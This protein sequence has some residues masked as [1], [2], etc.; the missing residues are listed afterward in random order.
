MT[1]ATAGDNV[2]ML[3][4]R[5]TRSVD[6]SSG[7]STGRTL[8]PTDI[9]QALEQLVEQA[10]GTRPRPA[11]TERRDPAATVAHQRDPALPRRCVRT[12]CAN[13][14]TPT[15][16]RLCPACGEFTQAW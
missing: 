2:E 9:A 14:H 13:Y 4:A 12:S 1:R 7:R 8:Y 10:S 6:T 11:T 3:Y 5:W 16:E 15:A